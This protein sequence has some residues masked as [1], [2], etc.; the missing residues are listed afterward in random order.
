VRRVGSACWL[1]LCA[2]ACHAQATGSVGVVTDYRYRGISLSDGHPVAQLNVDRDFTDGAYAGLM[3][4]GVRLD[5]ERGWQWLPYA[6]IAR[7]HDGLRWEAGVQYQGFS[8]SGY[9]FVQWFAGI[10]G[11]RMQARLNYAPRYFGSGTSW[12]FEVDGQQRLSAHWR[13]LGHAGVLRHQRRAEHDLRVGLAAEWRVA[14]V[15]LAWVRA[16]CGPG[17]LEDEAYA[18]PDRN[19]LVLQLVHRW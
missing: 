18:P 16:C 7:E 4:S 2:G 11:D 9:D 17:Y 1:L 15:Q 3:L 5:D 8:K 12:Y 13:L 6:G 19:A 14:E 10:G